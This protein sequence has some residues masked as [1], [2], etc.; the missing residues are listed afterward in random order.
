MSYDDDLFPLRRRKQ[1][2]AFS[3]AVLQTILEPHRAVGSRLRRPIPKHSY[4]F[5]WTSAR[6]MF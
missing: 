1:P 5:F 4:L 6:P 3:S 2:M